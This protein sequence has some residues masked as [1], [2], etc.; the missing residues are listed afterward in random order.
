MPWPED[1]E[2]KGW[3]G[4]LR[5]PASTASH[6]QVILCQGKEWLWFLCPC[7]VSLTTALVP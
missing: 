6:S 3:M 5:T 4:G 1:L 7:V 2:G